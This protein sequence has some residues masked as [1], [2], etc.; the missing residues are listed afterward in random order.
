[1]AGVIDFKKENRDLYLPNIEP[2]LIKI[3][4]MTFVAIDGKGDSN[5]NNREYQTALGILYG[6]QKK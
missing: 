1:M 2:L 5:N 3:T 6:I 4:E